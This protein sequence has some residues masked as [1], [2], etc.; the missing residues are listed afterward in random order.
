MRAEG[1]LFGSEDGDGFFLA[2]SQ[3]VLC[4]YDFLRFFS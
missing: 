4:F 1:Y 3:H 2:D